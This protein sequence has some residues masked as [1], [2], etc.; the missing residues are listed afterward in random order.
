MKTEER[1]YMDEFIKELSDGWIF[2]TLSPQ[3]KREGIYYAKLKFKR[4]SELLYAVRDLLQVALHTLYND[5]LE[6]SGQIED[7]TAHL[8]SVLEIAVQ[9]LPCSEAEGLD[10]MHSLYRKIVK[11]REVED[12]QGDEIP[13]Q[14]T[15]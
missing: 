14:T 8:V 3:P 10:K 5:G 1:E 13:T 12:K 7:P 4:Y 6:N 9:L 2:G 15:T 11:D